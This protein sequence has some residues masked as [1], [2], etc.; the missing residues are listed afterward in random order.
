MVT[1]T[2]GLLCAFACFMAFSI[3][4]NI[5]LLGI[6][7]FDDNKFLIR[8]DVSVKSTE[9]RTSENL[10]ST[11]DVVNLI[12]DKPPITMSPIAENPHINISVEV[13]KDINS[14]Q[15]TKFHRSEVVGPI[16]SYINNGGKIPIILLTCNR[17]K[18]L[19]ETLASLVS[20][21]NHQTDIILMQDGSL[22]EIEEIAKKFD[23]ELIQNK[24]EQNI[25]GS[26]DGAERIAMHY[27]FSLSTAF[28]IRPETPAIII[29][30]DDLLFSPDFLEYFHFVAPILDVDE[31]VFAISAWNDN[32]F[33][34]NVRDPYQL[35]RSEFFPGLGWLLTRKLYKQELETQWPHSHWDHWLRCEICMLYAC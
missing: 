32:G 26:I 19:E 7:D 16:S 12:H 30:E 24:K 35:H 31:S 15:L 1:A 25:R 29:V 27:K 22:T 6:I 2:S 5:G 14:A 28:S 23:V 21:L 18:L 4:L 9:S 20:V 34:Q 17:P 33:T 13:Q 3:G 8:K 10:V 11:T